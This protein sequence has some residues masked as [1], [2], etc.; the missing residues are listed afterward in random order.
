MNNHTFITLGESEYRFAEI[1]WEK[2][3][4]NSGEL[5]ALAENKLGWKKS[6]TYTV[7][8]KLCDK[9]IFQNDK[10]MVSSLIKQQEIQKSASEQLI[11]GKFKG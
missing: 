3:P 1:I 7:L 6:T 10:A 5:V 4:V 8:K 2:E 9:G 11:N